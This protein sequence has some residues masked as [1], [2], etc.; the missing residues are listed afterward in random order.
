MADRAHLITEPDAKQREW[1]HADKA[2][3]NIRPLTDRR[4][5]HSAVHEIIGYE[6]KPQSRN[7]KR[8]GRFSNSSRASLHTKVYIID[9][10]HVIIGTMNLDPRSVQLNTEIALIIHSTELA[11]QLAALFE[12]AIAP[13][14]SSYHV[15][16]AGAYLEWQAEE[17]GQR[18]SFSSDPIPGFWRRVKAG[19]YALIPFEEHL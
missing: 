3:Y 12:K 8:Y 11:D 17:N 9:R 5:G 10:T 1:Y 15:V 13:G 16:Q 4:R 6:M 19:I 7:R 18:L 14:G 2:E